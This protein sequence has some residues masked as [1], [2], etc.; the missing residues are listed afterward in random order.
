[1]V[2]RFRPSGRAGI[3]L[4]LTHTMDDMHQFSAINFL[5]KARLKMVAT[6]AGA[7]MMV[8]PFHVTAWAAGGAMPST[9]GST[10]GAALLCVDH[11]DPSYF[12]SYMKQFFGQPY[13]SEGG[14]HWF[15]VQGTLWG[16]NITDVMVSDGG[17]QQVFVAASFKDNPAKLA[18]AI[19]VAA[20]IRYSNEDATQYS[21]LI[22]SLGSKIIYSGQ[23][24]RIY[25]AKYN[26][27][28]SRSHPH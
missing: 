8:V 25:C 5:P 4:R 14:A 17:Q 6:L 27:D 15:K 3:Y 20:G 26:L 19:A 23:G 28:S 24:S 11:V 10:I 7:V 1:M 16:A 21:P 22:S 18:D 2:A 13:K 12:F 9:F